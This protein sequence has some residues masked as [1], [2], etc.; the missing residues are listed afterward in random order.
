MP[1]KIPRSND[2][3]YTRDMAQTRRQ[4]VAEQ[5]GKELQHV[6]AYSFDPAILLSRSKSAQRCST[7][8][9]WCAGAKHVRLG[10]DASRGAHWLPFQRQIHPFSVDDEREGRAERAG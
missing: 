2:N 7:G 10:F 4:F 3:D 9:P 5:T 1:P 8:S 6:G